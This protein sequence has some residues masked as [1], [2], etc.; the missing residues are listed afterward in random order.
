MVTFIKYSI[1]Q[2]RE[3]GVPVFGGRTY[4]GMASY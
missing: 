2:Q 3:I 1:R 4:E